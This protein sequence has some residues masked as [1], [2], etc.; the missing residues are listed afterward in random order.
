MD[1]TPTTVIY[2]TEDYASGPRRVIAALIDFFV[3]TWLYAIPVMIVSLIWVPKEIREMKG[4]LAKQQ[5]LTRE[6]LGPTVFFST[7]AIIII[8]VFAYHILMRRL[9]GGTIG[10]RIAR[11]RLI[12]HDG[13]K[14]PW[15]QLMKRIL[16]M[17]GGVFTSGLVLVPTFLRKKR[18]ALHDV[19]A[20]TWMVRV[21]AV[22]EGPG[23]LIYKTRLFGTFPVT[24]ADVESLEEN[25]ADTDAEDGDSPPMATSPP[26]AT[27][28]TEPADRSNA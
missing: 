24:Y 13:N 16:L 20:G 11:I 25:A 27:P 15:P 14:P 17:I 1:E 21:N 18:Q 8:L 22:P 3:V 2:R 19:F 6:A 9:R 28:R 12:A 26:V 7:I 4:D 23:A 5:R 10:Y